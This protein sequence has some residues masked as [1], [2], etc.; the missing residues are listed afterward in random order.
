MAKTTKSFDFKLLQSDLEYLKQM[1]QNKNTST[2][3]E[4]LA[5]SSLVGKLQQYVFDVEQSALKDAYNYDE[6]EIKETEEYEEDDEYLNDPNFK[7]PTY[8]YDIQIDSD[9]A[10]GDENSFKAINLRKL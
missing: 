9:E 8:N 10:E 4:K 5:L 3:D 6:I 2:I 1:N 7:L